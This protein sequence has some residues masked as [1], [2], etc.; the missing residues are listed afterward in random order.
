MANVIVPL[1]Q[2]CE[3]LEAVTVIDLLRRAGISVVTAGLDDQPVRASRGTVLLPDMTLDEA[4]THDYDM[5]V[6][7]GGLPGA[8]HLNEDPRVAQ[9]LR[10]LADSEKFTAAICAAP[11]V[12]ATA[13]LLKGRRAT[14]FPGVLEALQLADT[15]LEQAPVVTDGRIITSRGPGTAMDFALE[16]IERLVGRDKREEVEAALQRP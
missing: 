15:T 9:L 6:L 5:A 14:A 12:L 8:D 7:P 4:L 2:G 3:E 16:L 11:K 13:G 10:K 1:A